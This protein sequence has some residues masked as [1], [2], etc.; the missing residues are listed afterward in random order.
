MRVQ[1]GVLQEVVYDAEVPHL[2]DTLIYEPVTA[3]AL[4]GAAVIRRLQSG[5]LRTYLIYLLGLLACCSRSFASECSRERGTGV[6]GAVQVRRRGGARAGDP[7]RHS[8]TEGT[9]AGTPGTFGASALSR[10]SSALEQ[11]RGCA[12]TAHGRSTSW[13]PRSSLPRC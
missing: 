4:R 1:R 6:A 12:A 8:A 3:G 10:A 2:F 13:R 11:E 5:S 9:A 7:G